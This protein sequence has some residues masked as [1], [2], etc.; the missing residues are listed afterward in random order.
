[1][2]QH[3]FSVIIP[4]YNRFEKLSKTLESFTRQ[5]IP[6]DDFEVIIVDDGSQDQT[7]EILNMTSASNFRMLSRGK[8]GAA[9]ARNWGAKES[10]GAVLVFL[11]D[12]MT[13]LPG[14]LKAMVELCESLENAVILGYVL[15]PEELKSQSIFARL[16]QPTFRIP[17]ADRRTSFIRITG[18]L[19]AIQRDHFFT[20]GMFKRVGGIPDW[21]DI[22]FGWRTHQAGYCFY[23]C[24]R[25]LGEHWD[26]ALADLGT[27]CRRLERR[28]KNAVRVLQ[29]YPGLKHYLDQFIYS[30]PVDWKKDPF[31]VIIRK[32]GRRVFIF[33]PLLWTLEKSVQVL[34]N[35]GRPEALLKKLYSM[36]T[37]LYIYRGF[38]E[39]LREF[40]SIGEGTPKFRTV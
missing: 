15:V 30:Y 10:D 4:T 22:I 37:S 28:S 31:Q 20:A 27:S 29:V 40:G 9:E 8:I 21:E 5:E 12:D 18:G 36:V 38:Q 39:G 25:G 1:M 16:Y 7:R 24:E 34:E 26:Y 17:S 32:I 19:L 35:F 3:R 2:S 13:L 23:L 6:E 14:S 33:K 11:D